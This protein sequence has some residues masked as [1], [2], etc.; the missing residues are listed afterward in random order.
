MG[1]LYALTIIMQEY[2]KDCIFDARGKQLIM[3]IMLFEKWNLLT[4]FA[5]GL[6]DFVVRDCIVL[7]EF[8]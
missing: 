8:L 1:N 5:R 4:I 2:R 6:F 7:Y 3:I